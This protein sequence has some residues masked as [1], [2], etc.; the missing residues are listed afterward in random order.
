MERR[1]FLWQVIKAM[2]GSVCLCCWPNQ[3]IKVNQATNDGWTPLFCKSGRPWSVSLLLARQGIDVNQADNDGFTPLFMASQNGHAE[4]VSLLLAKEGIDVNQATIMEDATF[5]ASPGGHAECVSL[6]L[7]KQG[8]KMNQATN[9]GAMPL[10]IASQEWP[11]RCVF[12]ACQGRH[13]CEPGQNNG[14]TPLYVASGK[15]MRSVSLLLAKEGIDV[16]QANNNGAT[17]LWQV[18]KAMEWCLCCWPRKAST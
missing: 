6:L 2:G 14:V 5:M 18:R 10:H 12:A 15:A 3:G 11:C 16:N 13:R 7:A 4:C 8:I 1:H 9:D 17:P